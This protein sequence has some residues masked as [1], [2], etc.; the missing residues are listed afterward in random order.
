MGNAN[1]YQKNLGR[2]IKNQV[3]FFERQEK[4]NILMTNKHSLNITVMSLSRYRI[5]QPIDR[6]FIINKF[7]F[8]IAE[9]ST[10]ISTI[11][12]EI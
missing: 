9:A 3:F 6:F 5:S 4:E 8:L 7:I 1:Y 10:I 11:T 12:L 2:Q